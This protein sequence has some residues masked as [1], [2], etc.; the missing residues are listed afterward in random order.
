MRVAVIGGGRVGTAVAVLLRRAG[1]RIVGVSGSGPT[2]DR[3]SRFLPEV[4]V[5]EPAEAVSEAELVLIGV[6]DDLIAPT[7]AS[8]AGAFRSG[9]FVAHLSGATGL[10]VLDPAK[11]ADGHRLCIHPLQTFPDVAHALDRIP[12][13]SIAVT[14]DD[15]EGYLVAERIADDLLGDPFRVADD[16]KPVYHAA[17]VFASNYVL[18]ASAVAAELFIAAGMRDPIPTMRPLQQATLDNL[19]SMG[20]ERAL[21]GPAVRGDVGTI[22]RNLEALDERS[23]AFVPAYLAMARLT[24]DLAVRGGR[25]SATGRTAVQDELDAWS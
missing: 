12:G 19:G 11:A 17:A 22:R 23:P 18:T 1:H 6:P 5:R 4:R 15:E 10:D 2:R 13:C 3:V 14:A 9:Q 7:A 21:T 25:L 20:A 8:L 16:L 24:L